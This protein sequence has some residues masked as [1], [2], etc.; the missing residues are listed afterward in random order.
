MKGI[1]FNILND[2]VEEKFG[3]AAWDGL[4]EST[5]S[6][7]IFIAPE[8]Y[9]DE[10]LIAL[11]TAA[12]TATGIPLQDLVFSFG[13]YMVPKFFDNYPIFFD[14]H[15]EL[16][17]FLLTVDQVIH[18]EVRKLYPEAGLPEFKYE[19]AQSD[20]LTMIYQSPRKLC[21]L[22]EGLISGSAKHFDQDYELQHATCMHNGADHCELDLTLLSKEKVA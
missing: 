6:D 7:G 14:A 16:I 1:V 11:V 2:M 5:G 18:V 19:S 15:T 12:E 17:P 22:A 10:E 8:T 9:P 20:R 13:E 4:L 21:Q 3:L